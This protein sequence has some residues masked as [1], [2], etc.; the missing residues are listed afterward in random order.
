MLQ[1]LPFLLLGLSFAS[2][3]IDKTP[4]IWGTFLILSFGIGFVTANVSVTGLFWIALLA[5]L[6][7]AYQHKSQTWLFLA[8]VLLSMCY[9]MHLIGGFEPLV[10]TSNFSMN[11]LSPC[12]GLFPLAF[13]VPLATNR[14]QWLSTGKWVLWGCLGIAILAVLATIGQVTNC[15]VKMPSFPVERFFNN[16]FLVAIPE[17]G[18]YRGFLQNAFCRYFRDIRFG[19]VIAL[20]VTTLLFTATHVFW[21]PNLSVLL[22]VFLSGLLYG[23]IYLISTRIESA[24]F[25]HFLLNLIHMTCFS[26]HAM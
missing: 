13:C 18:F 24:I 10:F 9:K 6:W 2:L 19:K 26:Y 4:L 21:S 15:H 23:G 25:C 8:L 16:L 20:I 1:I 5:Y 7:I 11:L 12:V 14:N 22:F 17:E 3:W